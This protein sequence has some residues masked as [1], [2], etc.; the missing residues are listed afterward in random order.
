[1]HYRH[2]ALSLLACLLASQAL[3]QDP[4]KVEPKHYRLGFENEHVQV[5]YVHYGPHEKSAIHEHPAG[6]VVNIT[7]G[8]LMFTDENGNSHEVTSGPGEARWFPAH[9]HTVENLGSTPYNAVYIGIRT[10]GDRAASS[11]SS[12]RKQIQKILAAYGYTAE[13]LPLR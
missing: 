9:K 7:G 6:V 1:M 3:A 4:T 12:T 2:F 13:N 10:A 11:S 5:V 8:H